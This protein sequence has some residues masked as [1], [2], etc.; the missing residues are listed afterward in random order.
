MTYI[1]FILASGIQQRKQIDLN[2]ANKSEDAL[3][4]KNDLW[5]E[6]NNK[7]K[8]AFTIRI[9]PTRKWMEKNLVAMVSVITPSTFRG[10]RGAS[11]ELG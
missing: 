4:T 6:N 9:F 7:R 3:A 5:A 10:P 8:A 11:Q 1:R 2:D